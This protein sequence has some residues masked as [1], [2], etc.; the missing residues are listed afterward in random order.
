[1][2]GIIRVRRHKSVIYT[3]LTHG[4]SWRNFPMWMMGMNGQVL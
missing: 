1:M 3:Q 4:S 2:T